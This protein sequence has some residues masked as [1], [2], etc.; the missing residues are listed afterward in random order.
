[1]PR[2]ETDANGMVHLFPDDATDAEVKAALGSI[3]PPF[4]PRLSMREEAQRSA[5]ESHEERP[6]QSGLAQWFETELRPML[7]KVAHPQTISDIAQLLIPDANLSGVVR[8]GKNAAQ[9]ARNIPV[10]QPV[11]G[12][13]NAASAVMT[14]PVVGVIEPR[15]AHVGKILGRAAEAVRGAPRAVAEAPITAAVDAAP[16]VAAPVAQAAPVAAKAASVFNPTQA[17]QAA[18]DAFT[19]L[20]TL[21]GPA[22]ASNAM[23]LIRRGKAPEEAVAI[24]LKNRPV[25]TGASAAAQLAQ[26][27]GTPSTENVA[28]RVVSRN[29]TG[30]WE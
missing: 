15:A 29:A 22:E 14:N 24:I 23:E 30:R 28:S 21:P 19:K 26:R 27:L 11:A 3:P 4:Q 9:A 8:A 16:A 1:M 7:E 10:R 18:K 17:L 2:R 13:L 6:N 20:G 5:N 25:P 12:A